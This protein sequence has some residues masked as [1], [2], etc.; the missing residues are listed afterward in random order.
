MGRLPRTSE[1]LLDTTSAPLSGESSGAKPTPNGLRNPQATI[2]TPV[3]SMLARSTAEVH[4]TW[5]LT[6]WPGSAVAPNAR[7][8][9]VLTVAFGSLPS[10]SLLVQFWPLSWTSLHGMS[11]NSGCALSQPVKLSLSS[12]TTPELVALPSPQY[13]LP[14]LPIAM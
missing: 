3:P 9:P 5:P 4:G 1:P 6:T 12:P 8:G 11:W 10:T 14:S 13:S 7:K 2:S